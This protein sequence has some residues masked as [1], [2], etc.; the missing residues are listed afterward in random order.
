MALEK[1]G[2]YV[3]NVIYLDKFNLLKGG[4]YMLIKGQFVEIS[5]MPT[6]REHYRLLGY[7]HTGMRKK[8]MVKVD[9]L[10]YCSHQHVRVICDYCGKEFKKQYVNLLNERIDGK[11]CCKKCQPRRFAESC[12]KK[13][14]V[15]NPFQLDSVIRKTRETSL[16]KYGTERPCQSKVIKEKIAETNK[17]R[18][19]NICTLQSEEIKKKAIDTLMKR[20]GVD[21]A[22]KSDVILEK[23]KATNEKKYGA[24]NIAHTPLIS[25]KIKERNMEKYGVPYTTQVPEIIAKM[26]QSLYKNGSV[27]SSKAE[28]A[29]CEL[30]HEMYGENNCEDNFALDRMNM[31]CLV[32]VDGI[33]IDFEYD[34][35]YWHRDREDYDR[36][37]NYYLLDRG[38]RIVRISA[39]KK[40]DL[41]S[42][43]QI[44]EAVDYLVKGNHHLVY[45]DMN[46]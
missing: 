4:V 19:G 14:G 27:P 46:T 9:D 15:Q 40:D 21:S 22:F 7:E 31:D 29:M 44:I 34:G 10:C 43:E 6:N 42:K 23:I 13:Y 1:Y 45:I 20:Y 16:K 25:Q 8:F 17:E 3:F 35:Y 26:R 41:P 30:L 37:R 38:Y 18:Y 33:L 12:M 5:W 32:N 28:I 36:R 24:G 39:N 11:D 2:S